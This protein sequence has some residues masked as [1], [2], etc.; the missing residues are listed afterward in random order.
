[1]DLRGIVSKW[2]CS[3]LE[4]RSQYVQLN[5]MNSV[6]QDVICGVSQGS[7]L[8]PKLFLLYINYICNVSNMLDFILYADDTNVFYKHEN[9]DMMCKIVIVELD[10]LCT[11]LALN[12]LALNISKTNFMIFSNHK[13]IE[14]SISIDGVNL[15]KV[16]SL[17]FLGVCIDHQIT[18]KDHI[19]YISDKLSKSVAIIYR[20]KALYCLYNVIF[21]PHFIYCIEVWGNTYVNNIKPVFILKKSYVNCLSLDHTSK[22]FSQLDIL[23][24]YDLIDFSTCIFMYEVFHKLVPLTLQS[25]FSMSSSKK[26]KNNFDVMFARTRRKQ[27]SLTIKG[28]SLWN[29][30]HNFV[31]LSLSLRIYKIN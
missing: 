31:K 19:T 15:Q 1:M 8:G 6:L 21:K 26:Y 28:V 18:W 3:Y 14:H 16:D 12:K 30:L 25:K 20:A 13:T 7:N 24:I 29:S 9:I 10:K 27:F 4:N 5:G 22:M 2:I 23:K 17:R 11:W